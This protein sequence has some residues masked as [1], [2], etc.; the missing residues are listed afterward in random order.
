MDDTQRNFESL[1]TQ[2][3]LFHRHLEKCQTPQQRWLV[4]QGMRIV[5]QE[6][7][8][9]TLTEQFASVESDIRTVAILPL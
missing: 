8:R 1:A 9:I 7:D 4:L 6:L 5:I 2:F 3:E